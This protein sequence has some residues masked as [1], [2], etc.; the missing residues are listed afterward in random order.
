MLFMNE[1]TLLVGEIPFN[2]G[3]CRNFVCF[4]NVEQVFVLYST[5]YIFL[6]EILIQENIRS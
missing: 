5:L 4:A 1:C 6:E 3:S 2:K